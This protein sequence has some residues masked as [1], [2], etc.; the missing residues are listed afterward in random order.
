[1]IIFLNVGNRANMAARLILILLTWFG[2]FNESCAWNATGHKLVSQIAVNQL[3][4][5]QTAYLNDLNHALD[6]KYPPMSLVNAA[7]WLDVIKRYDNSLDP[8]HY[9]NLPFSTEGLRLPNVAKVNAVYAINRAIHSLNSCKSTTF[10]KG[11]NLRILLHVVGD[12]HQPMHAV[13]QVSKDYPFGDM[14][15]NL[16][17]LGKN[18]VAQNLHG[19]WD[20]AGGLLSPPTPMNALAIKKLAKKI[21]SRWPCKVAQKNSGPEVWAQESHAIARSI[22]Y[23]IRKN[24]P[25][26]AVY[27]NEVQRISEQRIA[28]AGC[29]LATQLRALQVIKQ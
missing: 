12:L 24:K 29:R 16:Y 3:S 15:G 27:K 6:S 9:I 26:N 25:P 19:Y 20:R 8:Y 17:P 23:G 18:P 1:M 13:S 14:G 11:F 21:E 7:I 22:S 5:K 2:W 28:L 4:K 10:E